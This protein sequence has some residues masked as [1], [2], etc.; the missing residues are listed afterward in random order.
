V[1]AVLSSLYP[2]MTVILATIFLRERVTRT[3]AVGI[4]LAVAAIA[5]IAAGTA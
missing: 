4:A 2:V 1:A 5:C 3:H